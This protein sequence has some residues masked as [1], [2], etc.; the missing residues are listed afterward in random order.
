MTREETGDM[1]FS[2]RAASLQQDKSVAYAKTLHEASMRQDR[3]HE[4]DDDM[5][6]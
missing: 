4:L 1:V 6:L 3:G 5:G 2:Q